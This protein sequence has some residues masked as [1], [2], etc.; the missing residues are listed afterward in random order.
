MRRRVLRHWPMIV[1]AVVIVVASLLFAFGLTQRARQLDEL[2]FDQC[3][4]NEIQDAV[5][6]DQLQAAKRRA[7]AT[8][9]PSL[10]LSYQLQVLNDGILA[11]EP[12]DEPE[13]KPPEG[14]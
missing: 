8:I 12:P 3:I 1:G 2:L 7:R 11:L 5:I 6:V 10:E 13:C 9:P 4:A 14:R